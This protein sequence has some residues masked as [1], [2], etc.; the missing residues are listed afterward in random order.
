MTK[1]SNPTDWSGEDVLRI[2][3]SQQWKDNSRRKVGKGYEVTSRKIGNKHMQ[4]CSAS[5]VT[6]E[7]QIKNDIETHF[8][9]TSI[10]A[11]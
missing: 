6:K 1:G 11:V 8:V 2:S 3:T 9:S 5:L 10:A 7:M 4:G